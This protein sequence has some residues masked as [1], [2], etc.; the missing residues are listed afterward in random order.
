M[1]KTKTQKG[2][3]EL[4]DVFLR[5][6]MCKVAFDLKTEMICFDNVFKRMIVLNCLVG[7][8]IRTRGGQLHDCMTHEE[9]IVFLGW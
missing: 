4:N 7:S 5:Q 6:E 1:I 8:W 9:F 2:S 3:G